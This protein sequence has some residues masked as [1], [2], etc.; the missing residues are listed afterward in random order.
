[1]N[2]GIL[3][4]VFSRESYESWCIVNTISLRWFWYS[5]YQFVMINLERLE[6]NLLT[7]IRIRVLA[8]IFHHKSGPYQRSF[9]FWLATQG[10]S[11]K[12]PGFKPSTCSAIYHGHLANVNSSFWKRGSIC[13]MTFGGMIIFINFLFLTFCFL[14]LLFHLGIDPGM[15]AWPCWLPFKGKMTAK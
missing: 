9:L 5:Y 7:R 2:I 14:K 3:S 13:E 11:I 10:Q 4:F 15:F 8:T 6:L 12:V 1:M